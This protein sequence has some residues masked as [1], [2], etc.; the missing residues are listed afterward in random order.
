V[1]GVTP[2]ESDSNNIVNEHESYGYGGAY[3]DVT[4]ENDEASNRHGDPVWPEDDS[5]V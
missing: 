5:S 4:N 3:A 1:Y 2:L